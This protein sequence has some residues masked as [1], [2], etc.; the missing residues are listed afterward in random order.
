MPDVFWKYEGD[1][2]CWLF[3]NYLFALAKFQG[4]WLNFTDTK[5]WYQWQSNSY[6]KPFLFACGPITTGFAMFCFGLRSVVS[7]IVFD[8]CID[9]CLKSP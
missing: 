4:L 6:D 5:V 9:Q 1:I 7:E 8:E 2:L 3:E